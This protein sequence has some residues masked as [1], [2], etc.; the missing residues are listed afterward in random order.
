MK[1]SLTII[2]FLFCQIASSQNTIKSECNRLAA[3]YLK[4][5]PGALTIGICDKG[6]KQIFY[7]GETEKSNNTL[8]DS[9]SI[10]EI[11]TLTE[12][13][14]CILFADRTLKGIMHID[15]KLQ[16]YLPVSVPSPIYQ[17][18]VCKPVDDSKDYYSY[19]DDKNMRI[20]IKPYLCTPDTTFQ[21]QPIILCYL[22]SH[23]SG[24]PN[25]PFNFSSKNKMNP[26]ADYTSE[27]LYKFLNNYELDKSIGFHYSYSEIG[28]AL[29]GLAISRKMNKDYD[30]IL[31]KNFLDTMKMN[32]TRIHLSINQNKR[33]LQGYSENGLKT[34]PWTADVFAS[35]V[36]LKT[37]PSDMMKFISQ[38]ISVEKNYLTNLLNYTH[39]SRLKPGG[40]FDENLEIA[41]GWKIIPLGIESQ[42]IVMQS[43]MTGGFAA[44]AGFVETSHTAVFVLSSVS[45]DVNEIGVDV[46][47]TI[48]L[49]SMKQQIK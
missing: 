7:Y 39:N 32:D 9:N 6:S 33:L 15:D 14:T 10:F 35:V 17:P 30:S 31:I 46:L 41:M 44:F 47:K 49:N 42:K 25:L 37:T 24:L 27:N 3:A 34:V 45:R 1:F 16:D 21:P 4:N 28:I 8:P 36:G 19:P 40:L 22:A 20:K 38:N 12:A 48:E 18:V 2:L 23:T 43:G 5:S 11:G 29:L 26:Y 13:F